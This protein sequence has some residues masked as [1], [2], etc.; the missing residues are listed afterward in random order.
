MGARNDWIELL[1]SSVLGTKNMR[2]KSPHSPLMAIIFLAGFPSRFS[3]LTIG[4]GGSIIKHVL[5]TANITKGR[6]G[7]QSI[8]L[9]LIHFDLPTPYICPPKL[10]FLFFLQTF[11][12]SIHHKLSPVAKYDEPATSYSAFLD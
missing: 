4:M 7:V 1:M 11:S 9:S 10:N 8:R 12:A 6:M 2:N 3:F 5:Q